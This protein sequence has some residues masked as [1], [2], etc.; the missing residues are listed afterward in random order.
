MKKIQEFYRRILEIPF[1]NLPML[2][3]R[4]PGLEYSPE[5]YEEEGIGMSCLESAILLRRMNERKGV[6]TG[7]Y[8]ASPDNNFIHYVCV[9]EEEG[10]YLLDHGL[11][12]REPVPIST[13]TTELTRERPPIIANISGRVI[14]VKQRRGDNY[15]NVY[16]LRTSQKLT[17]DE[18]ILRELQA[19]H[20]SISERTTTIKI[21][22]AD[23]TNRYTLGYYRGN[24]VRVNISPY[25]GSGNTCQRMDSLEQIASFFGIDLKQLRQANRR[26]KNPI[27][28]K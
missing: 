9:A 8:S 4:R 6:N 28:L 2:L 21:A 25:D 5:R 13:K 27:P 22:M 11:S 26:V 17:E 15:C 12:L 20:D 3:D 1:S 18:E 14:F 7:I 16:S 10:L 19:A 24:V 23:E